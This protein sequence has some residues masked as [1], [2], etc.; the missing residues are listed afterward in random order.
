MSVGGSS[1]PP[2]PA[3]RYHGGLK[4][5]LLAALLLA[6]PV[7]LGA[8]QGAP[9]TSGSNY[10]P[11]P[12][13]K[14]QPPPPAEPA[15]PAAEEK[16]YFSTDLDWSDTRTYLKLALL[17]GSVLLALRAFRQMRGES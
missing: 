13:P 3:F 12:R 5:L 11:P 6:A 15:K 10:D 2:R 14:P 4:H 1:R 7:G 8:Q 9:P 17:V 16:P